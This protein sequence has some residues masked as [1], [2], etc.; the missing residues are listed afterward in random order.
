MDRRIGFA[1][2]ILEDRD[3]VEAVN[4]IISEHSGLILARV[5]LPCRDKHIAVITLVVEATTDE[6]G[7]FTG[8]LGRVEGVSVKS[9]LAKQAKA[10]AAGVPE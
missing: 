4:R 6:L 1:G 9:G 7:K 3:S 5:G 2:I 8:Q 10:A